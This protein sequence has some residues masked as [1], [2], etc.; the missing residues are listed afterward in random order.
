MSEHTLK[1]RVT[2]VMNHVKMMNKTGFL[3]IFFLLFLLSSAIAQDMNRTDVKGKKQG[4][5]K[6]YFPNQV[7]K[8][9]GTYKDDLPQGVFK[10]Y[11]PS[12]KLRAEMDYK[13]DG[14]SCWAVLFDSSGVKLGEGL[15][16]DKLKS[17]EWKMYAEDG[18][19]RAVENYIK[20]VLNG[21]YRIYY[22]NLQDKIMEEGTY[23]NGAKDQKIKQ[24][25]PG[26]SVHSEVMYK[27]GICVG[28]ALYFHPNGNKQVQGSHDANGKRHG[29]WVQYDE[30]GL[31][32][33]KV[34]Y[35]HGGANG[36]DAIIETAPLKPIK[37]ET[38]DGIRE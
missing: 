15:Y 8:S 18:S 6:S 22:Q 1:L 14:K 16:V 27:N 5:W 24:Y 28:P 35:R 12:G 37:V 20:G 25:Y 9:E 23:V 21:P 38:P 2:F 31:P 19:L 4:I 29:L 36:K 17:G 26:G 32:K 11:F 7:L 10:M 33:N 3:S 34:V 13:E 30:K